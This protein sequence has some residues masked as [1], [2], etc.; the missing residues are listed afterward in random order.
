MNDKIAQV[1]LTEY[2]RLNKNEQI[3]LSCLEEIVDTIVPHTVQ[4]IKVLGIINS[5]IKEL[6]LG[7]DKD[8]DL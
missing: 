1:L 6:K 3:L 8:L 2:V 7:E 4:D 5:H